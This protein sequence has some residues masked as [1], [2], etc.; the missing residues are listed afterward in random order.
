MKP[1]LTRGFVICAKKKSFI[2]KHLCKLFKYY[3]FC[4]IEKYN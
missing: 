2:D 4:R 3:Y 1:F